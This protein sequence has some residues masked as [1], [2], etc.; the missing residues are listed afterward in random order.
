MLYTGGMNMRRIVNGKSCYRTDEKES[1][2]EPSDYIGMFMTAT[3][4]S[5]VP[6]SS[7]RIIFTAK[8]SITE[9]PL[10]S[11]I[12]YAFILG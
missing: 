4:M 12:L 11:H 6:L 9:Y 10:K 1:L 5:S 3:V 7:A 2:K 8:F